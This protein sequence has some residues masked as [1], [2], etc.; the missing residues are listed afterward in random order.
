VMGAT[1]LG[2]QAVEYREIVTEQFTART[3]VYGSLFFTITGF[4]G[5]HVAVG[6]V[7]N[8]WVQWY[9]GRGRFS[10]ERHLAVENVAL[11]WHFV[12]AVWVFILFSLYLSPHLWS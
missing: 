7:M 10:A 6:L 1:F 2:F 11:Y 8:G 4:H 3:N 9:A 5:L 12:D